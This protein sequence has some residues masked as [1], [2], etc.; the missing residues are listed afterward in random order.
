M[1]EFQLM[2]NPFDWMD[3]MKQLNLLLL[4]LDAKVLDEY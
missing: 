4:R 3:R 2:L 1:A